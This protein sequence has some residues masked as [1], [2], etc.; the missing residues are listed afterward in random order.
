MHSLEIPRGPTRRA[1]LAGA[2]A[3]LLL[4]AAGCASTAPTGTAPH[5]RLRLIG[6]TT[7]PHRLV[8]QGTVIGGLSGL[9]YDAARDLWVALSDDR[10]D[11]QPAR[12]YTLRLPV[13]ADRLGPPEWQQAVTLRQPDG[14]P[15]PRRQRG[16]AASDSPNGP[17]ADPESIRWHPRT[18]NLLWSSEGDGRLGQPPF[19]REMATDGRHLREFTLPPLLAFDPT[20]QRGP[21]DNL[22]LEGLAPTPDGSGLWAAMEAAL[23]QDGPLPTVSA[24]GSPCRFT[25]FDMISG[26]AVRQIA[27][28]PDA[29]PLLPI[30]AGAFADNGVSEILMLDAHRLL[31]LERAYSTGV[32]NSLRLYLV[33]TRD[34]TD[35][36]GLPALHRGN[37]R[38]APKT[39]LLDFARVGLSRLDNTEG[40]AWGP[41]LPS[42]HR[43][44][45]FAS[46]DNF[47]PR[48]VTQFV[49]FEFIE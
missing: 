28:Q 19:I 26:Q 20:G 10:S 5:P 4:G 39:L 47:N 46:D 38:A 3:A 23:L 17:V 22:T 15:F 32:G 33:D 40:M 27:Y 12:F 48:Q 8:F 41:R 30:P 16:G 18:G 25:L 31:V 35:T 2:G 11:L 24:P 21:R 44:L 7:V 14:S 9:D 13:S 45:V 42:G 34:A 29:I 43:T 36:L 49:A 1:L 37:H 6:E